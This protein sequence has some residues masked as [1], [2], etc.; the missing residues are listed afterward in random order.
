MYSIVSDPPPFQGSW[1]E[2]LHQDIRGPNKIQKNLRRLRLRQVKRYTSFVSSNRFPPER[3]S[4][5]KRIQLSLTITV[6]GVFNLYDIS[7]E[8]GQKHSRK[9]GGNHVASV[10]HANA[11]QR[12]LRALWSKIEFLT[13]F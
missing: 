8:V 5:L 12:F 11:T 4:I 6:H 3:N 10:D 7:S 9:W 2:V 1:S 13:L